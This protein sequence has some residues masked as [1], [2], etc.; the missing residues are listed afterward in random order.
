MAEY[1]SLGALEGILRGQPGG[2]LVPVRSRD[3]KLQGS[4]L[5]VADQVACLVD[6]A[7]DPNVLG[8]QWIGLATW[9]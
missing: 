6:I 1:K 8:R 5:G 7:T 9:I 4:T 3:S 2:G